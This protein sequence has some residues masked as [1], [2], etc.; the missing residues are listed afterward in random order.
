LVVSVHDVAPATTAE[1]HAWLADLDGLGIRAV[2]LVIPGPWRGTALTDSPA[3]GAELRAAAETGH[4]LALHGWAHA[5]QPGG[6]RSRRWT[7]QVAA[8]GA[9]EFWSLDAAEAH[10]RVER[11]LDALRASGIEPQGFVPPGYLASPGSRQALA[12][13]GLRYWTSHFAVHDLQTR[14][15]HTVVAL[16]HRPATGARGRPLGERCGEFLIGRSPQW[17]TGRGRPLRLALHPDDLHRPGLR[18]ATL[19]AIEQALSLGARPLTYSQLL[20]QY[21]TRDIGR[22]GGAGVSARGP[23][24]TAP[25]TR[26]TA[27]AR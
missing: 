24:Q 18:E 9:G 11:G 5:A 3:F 1:T 27:A 12:A 10:D 22:E 16:S 20:E 21:A 4:E 25:P 19:R 6:A 7:G 23:A 26:G 15:R 2:L 14:T 8:R 13:S 17:F